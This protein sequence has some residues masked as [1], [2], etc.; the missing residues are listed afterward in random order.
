M[1]ARPELGKLE[2][3][4]K[5]VV[6]QSPNDMRGRPAEERYIPAVVA[7][8]SRVWAEMKPVGGDRRIWRMRMDT[9]DQATQY[10]GS[11]ASFATLEQHEW[12]Q[13]RDW[14]RE[15]IDSNALTVESRSPWRGREIELAEV[16]SG[17]G[18]AKVIEDL[19]FTAGDTGLAPGMGAYLNDVADK[20]EELT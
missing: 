11:N 9:Q 2:M 13:S 16:L 20:L 4:Q 5:V 3:G 15:V 14:A 8:V 10:S 19:R 6:R 17:R 1:S 7:R 18:L 12:D